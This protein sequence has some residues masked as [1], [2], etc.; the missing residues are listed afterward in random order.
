MEKQGTQK[1][2]DACA[3]KYR[4]K[5]ET[6]KTIQNIFATAVAEVQASVFQEQQLRMSITEKIMKIRPLIVLTSILLT[7]RGYAQTGRVVSTDSS[8]IHAILQQHNVCRQGLRLPALTWSPDLANDAAKWAQNLAALGEGKHDMSIRGQEGE[9]LWWGTANAY[10]YGEMVGYWLN[11][12]NAFV[13]G[14]YPN[15]TTRRSAVVGHYTQIVWKNTTSVGCAL[16]SD[17]KTDFLV[18]RYSPPGNVV[19][20]KPY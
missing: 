16:A 2:S 5:N 12:K 4:K 18:C 8:F 6:A 14:T 7:V 9:N 15:C 17:G 1:R 3:F 19:G 20:E 10:S 11:E 13:Y